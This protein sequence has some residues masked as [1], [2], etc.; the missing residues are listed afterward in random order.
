MQ[1]HLYR[2]GATYYWR[3]LVPTALQPILGDRDLRASLRTNLPETARSRAR[4]MDAAFD[5][6]LKELEQVVRAGQLVPEAVK[7]RLV[8]ELRQEI[9]EKAE[10]ARLTAGFR[11][12][13]EIEAAVAKALRLQNAVRGLLSSNDLARGQIEADRLLAREGVQLDRTSPE[14]R[15]FAK[16]VLAGMADAFGIISDNEQGIEYNPDGPR[17]VRIAISDQSDGIRTKEQVQADNANMRAP[18][19]VHAKALVASKQASQDWS[20]GHV[21]DAEKSFELWTTIVGDKSIGRCEKAN[22]VFFV[23]ELSRIP[24]GVGQRHPYK[25]MSATEAIVKADEIEAKQVAQAELRIKREKLDNQGASTW[26]S[27]HQRVA[28]WCFALLA[29]RRRPVPWHGR[30]PCRSRWCCRSVALKSGSWG[31]H[32]DLGQ[33]MHRGACRRLVCWRRCAAGPCTTL[34]ARDMTRLSAQA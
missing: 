21:N 18:F 9:I 27:L 10:D 6:A 15:R 8:R 32:L 34:L 3:R 17:P 4:Q 24:V 33:P 12:P 11:T 30:A 31:V 1:T 14:F 16:D 25:D 20:T 28:R 2:R 29:S 7:S 23:A 13:E 5:L 26:P 22:A 19:S